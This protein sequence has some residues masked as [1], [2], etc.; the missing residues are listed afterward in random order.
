MREIRFHLG[1]RIKTKTLLQGLE[2]YIGYAFRNLFQTT[3]KSKNKS[4][5]LITKNMTDDNIVENFHKLYYE[6]AEKTIYNTYWMGKKVVKCPLDL[7]IYQEIF[8]NIKPDF[9][10]ETG[11]RDGGSALFF[12][13]MCDI[14]GKGNVISVDI[15]SEEGISQHERITYLIGNSVDAKIIQNIK[16]IIENNTKV[17]NPSIIVI[18]DSD[19]TKKH[20]LAEMNLYSDLV[21]KGSYLIVEDTNVNGYPIE[22]HYGEGPMEA[23][24]EFLS[25]N[26]NFI[27]DNDMEKFF[28]TMNPHGYL[29]KMV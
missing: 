21:S 18:L 5:V 8:F 12:A 20:V 16:K 3:G 23:V 11:T 24:K 4:D 28:F 9:I 1:G 13:N 14:T 19:H 27:A 6:N 22:P 10:I 25:I 15:H 29:K 2:F 7:W 17:K 26:K